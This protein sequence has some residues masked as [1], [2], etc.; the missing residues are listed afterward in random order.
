MGKNI[1]VVEDEANTRFSLNVLLKRAGYNVSTAPDGTSAFELLD[2]SEEKNE[3]YDLLLTDLQ[4]P[5]MT[6]VELIR[7]MKSKNI[8]M[9]VIAFT[10]FGDKATI[11]ELLREGCEEYLDKPFS[12]EDLLVKIKQVFTKTNARKEEE[13]NAEKRFFDIERKL[14]S[15]RKNFTSLCNSVDSAISAY[16]EILGTP[17]KSN[18]INLASASVTKDKL[19]GDFAAV[20]DTKSGCDILVADVAGHDMGASYHTIM[21]KTFFDENT[22]LENSGENFFQILNKQ[23]LNNGMNERLVTALFIRINLDELWVESVSASHPRLLRFKSKNPNSIL[24]PF[25]PCSGNVLGIMD[26]PSFEVRKFNIGP[27]DR[28]IM[29]TDG[30]CSCVSIDGVS[31][32]RVK[33]EEAGLREFIRKHY[34]NSIQNMVSNVWQ[35]IKLF[36]KSKY[37]D[38]MLLI[39]IE[40]PE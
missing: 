34:W 11:I 8:T 37:V 18:R 5:E 7:K 4:M 13:K 27:G 28:L 10:G 31:G 9:P 16:K 32:K 25:S 30:I 39:G 33:L 29:Y 24:R 3:L 40:I 12:E 21:L 20:H 38:D 1:L 2:K 26:N 22:R 14:E 17:L 6:G 36:C 19:G 23:L 15:Y 35:D